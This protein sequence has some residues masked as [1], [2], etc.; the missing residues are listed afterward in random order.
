MEK[1][2]EDSRARDAETGQFVREDA[3]LDHPGLTIEDDKFMKYS[4]WMKE[5]IRYGMIL[6]S[7]KDEMGPLNQN[8]FD[9]YTV[10]AVI[11][12]QVLKRV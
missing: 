8:E 3:A 9:T 5:W 11:H 2:Y 6:E 4:P 12:A 7:K 1:S 10:A